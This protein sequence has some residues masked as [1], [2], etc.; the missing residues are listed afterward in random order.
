M[1]V[2]SNLHNMTQLGNGNCVGLLNI[3][4]VYE[5]RFSDYGFYILRCYNRYSLSKNMIL[6]RI[7]HIGVYGNRFPVQC[8]N[9]QNRIFS[10]LEK[11]QWG[12]IQLI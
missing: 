1:L 9:N 4:W 10:Y 3:K 2:Q 8:L 11:I 12:R 5:Y 6:T 7:N